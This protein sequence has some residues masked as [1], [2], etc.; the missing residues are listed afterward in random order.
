LREAE[1]PE[2]A[3][4]DGTLIFSSDAA[5]V[6]EPAVRAAVEQALAAVAAALTGQRQLRLL[7]SSMTA[8]AASPQCER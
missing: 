1:F 4:G 2:S 3:L 8:L 6:S 5:P 7:V